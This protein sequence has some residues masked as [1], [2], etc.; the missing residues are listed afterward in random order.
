MLLSWYIENINKEDLQ[1]NLQNK[2]HNAGIWRVIKLRNYI[3]YEKN[4]PTEHVYKIRNGKVWVQE[5]YRKINLNVD[6]IIE[7]LDNIIVTELKK[8]VQGKKIYVDKSFD[9]VLPQSEKQFIGNLPSASS[10]NIDKENLLVA[11]HWYNVENNRVDLDLKVISNEYSIGWDVQYKEGNKLIFSG[12]VTDAPYPNGAT[13]CIYI[14]KDI[15]KTI[16]SVKVNNYTSYVDNIEYDIIIAKGYKNKL[17]RNY[18][19]DPNDIIV[20]IP[21]VKIE[22]GK[23]EHSIGNVIVSDNDIKLIFTDLCTSNKIS[24]ENNEREDILRKYLY[25]ENKCKC[26]LNDYL[27]KA[28]A[29]IVNSAED[30]DI[31][32]GVNELNKDSLIAL[33]Q[34]NI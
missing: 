12:D 13:E 11:I 9:F 15:G 8:N 24:S 6:T 2:L 4:N 27:Q 25:K 32:L 16:F 20:K 1:E 14:D 17:Q 31:N 23:T 33:F 18:I 3:E 5:K 28:G 10:L 34:N 30:C 26:K 7:I 29:I 19:I 22:R 21:K